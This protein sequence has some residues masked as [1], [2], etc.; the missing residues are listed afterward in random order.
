MQL[1]LAQKAKQSQTE[2]SQAAPNPSHAGQEKP[3][4]PGSA[5]F[6]SSV[7]LGGRT[8]PSQTQ[9]EPHRSKKG[10]F[11]PGSAVFY[12]SS[13][14]FGSPSLGNR[15][16]PNLSRAAPKKKKNRPPW[17]G[18]L[19]LLRC[20]LARQTRPNRTKPSQTKA[21]PHRAKKYTPSPVLLRFQELWGV[22]LV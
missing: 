2:P 7:R 20:G 15:A 21:E 16:K 6:F 22:V 14:R 11:R 17:L 10:P 8:K 5:V 12:F 4:H 3:F 13:V 19:L 1:G 18:S 9:A